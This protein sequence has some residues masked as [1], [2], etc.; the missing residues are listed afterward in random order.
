MT[1]THQVSR[2]GFLGAAAATALSFV[3]L[4][5]VGRVRAQPASRAKLDDYVGRLS[6]NENPLGPSPA[7]LAALTESAALAHRYPDWYNFSLE[8]QIAASHGFANPQVVCAGAGATEVIRLI[9]DALLGPGDELVTATPTYSQMAVEATA[10]GATVVSVPLDGNQV[11]DL[12]GILAAIGPA[13][14][15][16]SLVNPNNPVGTV[17]DKLA[18]EGFLEALPGNITVVVDEAYHDYVQAAHYESCLRYVG[19]GKP[20][21]VVRTFSKAHGLAGARIGYAVAA[22]SLISMIA[23]TQNF[24]MISRPSQAAAAAALADFGHITATVDLNDQAQSLLR[25][26]LT[27]LG[28][29]YIPSHTNFLMFDTGVDAQVV[30][31]Q[32]SGLGYQVRTG[33]GMP[34]HIRV[35]TGT[36]PEMQ[37]FLTALETVLSASVALPARTPSRLAFSEVAPNPFNATCRL[38][39]SIPSREPVNL[40]VYDLKGR[41][42]R[43]LLNGPVEPGIQSVVWDGQDHAGRSVASGTYIFNLIQGEFADSR[44]AAYVK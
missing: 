21:I 10:N 30:A 41:K 22:A 29:S 40:S 32:L 2:R 9:A 33:W 25:T 13:T 17:F 43:T 39:L 31:G 8:S 18:M 27:N 28:L 15:L 35:S 11:I 7:A 20:L 14:R 19:E 23:S 16:V 42:I 38:K 6:Y 5:G 34:Q 24:G 26:G 44:R 37:G 3:Y 4:P 1:T 12:V 36:L